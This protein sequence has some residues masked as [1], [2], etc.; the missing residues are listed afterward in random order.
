MKR[1][2]EGHWKQ[3]PGRF[4]IIVLL[5]V[6]LVGYLII[7]GPALMVLAWESER[8]A[9]FGAPGGALPYAVL[10][11]T[12]ITAFMLFVLALIAFIFRV[13]FALVLASIA[14]VGG[15]LVN[16]VVAVVYGLETVSLGTQLLAFFM[17]TVPMFA[18]YVHSRS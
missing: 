5:L 4:S 11:Y 7:F 8:A 14:G 10:V 9:T 15:F 17:F 18:I 3:Q 16:I 12:I 13:R 2:L 6:H 1:S